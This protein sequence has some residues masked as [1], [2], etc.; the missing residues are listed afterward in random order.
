MADL[1]KKKV[2]LLSKNKQGKMIDLFLI[3]KTQGD[4]SFENNDTS[5][6]RQH[7]A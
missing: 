7:L 2:D 5:H 6:A 1:I 4:V 3:I